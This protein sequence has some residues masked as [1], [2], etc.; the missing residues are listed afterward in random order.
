MPVRRVFKMLHSIMLVIRNGLP[1]VD[2]TNIKEPQVVKS[3][4]LSDSIL[5]KI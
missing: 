3:V 5:P 1:T 2:I 4:E